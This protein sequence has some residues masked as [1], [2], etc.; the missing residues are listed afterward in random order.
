ML[1]LPFCLNIHLEATAAKKAG[2]QVVIVK[3]EGNAPLPEAAEKQFRTV[4]D[5]NQV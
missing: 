4:T 2:L 3:R 5:F 1:F